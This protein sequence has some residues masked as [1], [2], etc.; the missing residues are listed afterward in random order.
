MSRPRPATPP[1][2][3]SIEKLTCSSVVVVGIKVVLGRVAWEIVPDTI[4]SLG[5]VVQ[6]R[7]KCLS[8]WV[9][10]GAI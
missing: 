2:P 9:L 4:P 6:F 10:T 1:A 8:T 5:W 3:I 7:L